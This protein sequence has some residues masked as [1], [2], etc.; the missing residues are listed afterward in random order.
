MDM[1]PLCMSWTPRVLGTRFSSSN[2]PMLLIFPLKD[3]SLQYVRQSRLSGE[4]SSVRMYASH[5]ARLH[6][7]IPSDLCV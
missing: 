6:V 5:G 3:Y 1:W 4:R 7:G 2:H